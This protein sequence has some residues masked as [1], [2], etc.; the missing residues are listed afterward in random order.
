MKRIDV[1]MTVA[2]FYM[3]V[4]WVGELIGGSQREEKLDE[5][6]KSFEENGLAE[7]DYQNYLDLRR[8]G[9]VV[10]SGFGLGFERA[11]M[12]VTGMKNI[13]DVIP[14]PRYVNAFSQKN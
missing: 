11:V 12:Y 5:L 6:L 7:E 10:H 2:A 4:P 3:L 13:R 14:Y 9:T 8:Y 1:G